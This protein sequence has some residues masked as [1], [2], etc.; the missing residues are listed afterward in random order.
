MP[1]IPKRAALYIRVSTDEQARHGYSLAEQ[2]H[3]LRQYAD[4]H[5]YNVIGLYADEGVSARKS[6]SRR[7]EMQRLLEDIRMD[8][9]DIIIFKCLDRWFRSVADYYK[10]QEILDQHNVLWECSQEAIYNTTTTNGR[11]MLNLKLSIAQHESDQTG[12]R[13]KYVQ[14]GLKREGKV[15]TGHMPIGYRIGSDKRIKIDESAA[16]M[17]Q[18][19]FQYFVVH[20]TILGTFRMLREKYGYNKTEGAVGRTLQNRIYIG[21]YYGIKNF[22][23]ALIDE[24][25]FAQA[26]KT[27][28]GKTRHTRSGIIPLFFGLLRCPA[29]GRLL[30]PRNVLRNRKATTYYACRDHTHSRGCPHKT[31]WRE[32]RIEAALLSSLERELQKYLAD[33]KKASSEDDTAAPAVTADELRA[34]QARLK[35]LYVEGLIQRSEFDT[36]TGEINAQIAALRPHS[37]VKLSYFE[38]VAANN[39]IAR[40]DGMDKPAKKMF[41]SRILDHVLLTS[42]SPKPIFRSF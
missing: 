4:Q 16:A 8:A 22:C 20:R 29:C 30:T 37:K 15:I 21:E 9:I 35:E 14:D 25:L 28:S 2:E 18:D 7:K 1:K 27:F 3:D 23:P 19:M 11:L 31:Y 38:T 5:G 34:K 12:D 32:D 33:I 36:R 17:V 42:G 40:Y 13:V 24:G 6:F 41:W 39:L 10:V 26:Q